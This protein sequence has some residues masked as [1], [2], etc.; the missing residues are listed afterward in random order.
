MATQ[1]NDVNPLTRDH[2]NTLNQVLAMTGETAVMIDKAGKCEMDVGQ[3]K[4][5][6]ET[7]HRIASLIKQQFFPMEP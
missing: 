3:A 4:E 6:N 7:Q 2:L 1:N 5:E